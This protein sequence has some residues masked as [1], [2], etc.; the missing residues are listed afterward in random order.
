[1]DALNIEE[2]YITSPQPT[3]VYCDLT[4]G[5]GGHF[6]EVLRRIEACA[7]QHPHIQKKSFLFGIDWDPEAIEVSVFIS[8][9]CIYI[10][11]HI[12][13]SLIMSQ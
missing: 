9:Q 3:F 7:L 6:T 1:M 11:S 8:I 10:C 2:R 13:Y 12:A 4:L 5:G